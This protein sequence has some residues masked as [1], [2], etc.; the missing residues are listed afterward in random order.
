MT[1]EKYLFEQTSRERKRNARGS[2]A[3]KGGSRSK[4]C[5]LPS[6]KLTAKER[7]ELNGA[8]ET[9]NMV[10]IYDKEEFKALPDT[11]KV[12]YLKNLFEHGARSSDIAEVMGYSK[13]A[14]LDRALKN[15]GINLGELAMVYPSYHKR[16]KLASWE[17]F[18][19]RCVES[20]KEEVKRRHEI[21]AGMVQEPGEE[22]NDAPAAS[23]AVKHDDSAPAT[24]TPIRLDVVSGSIN[25]IG[26]PYAV[27]EKA[28]LAI[29]PSKE[30]HFQIRFKE[31]TE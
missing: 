10:K 23:D 31:V 20:L 15:Q 7:K 28:L 27:F 13:L 26:D 3:K 9:L 22:E 12:E 2:F 1:D 18:L 21:I 5:S 16:R 11:L 17:S 6:D 29:D 19:E 14:A 4:R 24:L 8:V 25:Y 30:Y